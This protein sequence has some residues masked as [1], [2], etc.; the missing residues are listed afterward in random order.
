[1]PSYQVRPGDSLFLIARRFGTTPET[2]A[3]A[4]GIS[5]PRM[6]YPGVTLQI[7][8][9]QGHSTFTANKYTVQPGDSLYL[10][11][12]RFGLPPEKLAAANGISTW[13]PIYPGQ[14]LTVPSVNSPP[15]NTGPIA[16]PTPVTG[17][18]QGDTSFQALWPMIQQY[19]SK[20]GAD[21]K[22]VAGIIAQESTWE[23]H[24]VHRDGTGHG[25]IGL[26]DRGMLPAF[27]KWSKF[28]VGRGHSA[29]IIPPALQVEFLA[30]NIGEMTRNHNGNP[31]AAVREW[32]RGLGPAMWDAKGS[33][34][35]NL[36]RGHINK[37]F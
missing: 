36:I 16:N 27:E 29:R 8:E 32:H 22:V 1:M 33:K 18:A 25:L 13:S 23:N 12:R 7:P 15:S 28:K 20:H 19:S 3:A 14:V 11:G 9:L 26:D 6:I 2:L 4:N 37:L 10:I 31:W 24:K 21:P 34:Y 17:P 5:D 30:K 35:E